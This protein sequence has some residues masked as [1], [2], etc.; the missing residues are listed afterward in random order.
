MDK[1]PD[2][3]EYRALL[4][5]TY[6]RLG[7]AAL[8]EGDAKASRQYFDEALPLREQLMQLD[9]QNVFYQ[10]DLAE[11]LAHCGRTNDAVRIADALRKRVADNP[12][13]LVQIAGCFARCAA[14]APDADR[15]R[16]I[17]RALEALRAAVTKDFKEARSL[18]I[19]PDLEPIRQQAGYKEILARLGDS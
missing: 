19:N 13:L 17:E 2:K 11:T 16:Y 4:A 6:H 18:K 8:V 15:P 5:R 14:A 3:L 1:Q 10:A 9:T 12:A 7:I